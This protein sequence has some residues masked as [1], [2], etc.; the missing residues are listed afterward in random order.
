MVNLQKYSREGFAQGR[1]KAAADRAAGTGI[2]VGCVKHTEFCVMWWLSGFRREITE[3]CASPGLCA[4][5][6]NFVPTFRYNLLILSTGVNVLDPEERSSS[7]LCKFLHY[8]T[9]RTPYVGVPYFLNRSWFCPSKDWYIPTVSLT[10]QEERWLR[11]FE[12]RAQKKVG[13]CS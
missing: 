11:V 12:I 3:N 4:A 13:I 10:I 8:Y 9:S 2:L 6:G 1:F 7:I 5:V